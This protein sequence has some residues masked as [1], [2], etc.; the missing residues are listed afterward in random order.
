MKNIPFE[1]IRLG[2]SDLR[3]TPICLGTMTFGEQVDEPTSHAVLSRS[4]ERGVDFIDTAEMYSVPTRQ[5]TYSVTESIIGR[6]FAANPGVRQK[7][8]L[9]TKVAGPSRGM[10]W[11]R[12]GTGMAAAD[13]VA[14]CNASLK[15]LQTDVIDLYQI[16]WPERNTPLFGQ[17]YFRPDQRAHADVDSRAVGSTRRPGEGRQG[18]LYRPVERNAVRRARVRPPGRAAF[19]AAHRDR[20][21][22]I[23]P[24]QSRT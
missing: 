17:I 23:Q 14:S 24:D 22:R 8:T 16:H 10:P 3:V 4:L 20:A 2:Q 9:A 13:I 21:E 1:K 18:S 6:W 12:E 19:T 15:R 7:L 5:E 11:V